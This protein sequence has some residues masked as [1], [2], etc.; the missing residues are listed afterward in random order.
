M[1]D[2]DRMISMLRGDPVGTDF[3][4]QPLYVGDVVL[5]CATWSRGQTL[6]AGLILDVIPNTAQSEGESNIIRIMSYIRTS[7]DGWQFRKKHNAPP[8]IR[9][10]R[11][12]LRKMHTHTMLWK[13]IPE[14][15]LGMVDQ[16]RLAY[17]PVSK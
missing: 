11:T 7:I 2:K 4:E 12:K 1:Q 9:S 3:L 15:L 16:D 14:D 5:Y 8:W 10:H 17:I 6:K 13:N